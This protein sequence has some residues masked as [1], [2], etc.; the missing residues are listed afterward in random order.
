[1]AD[2][3]QL[4]CFVVGWLVDFEA[5]VVLGSSRSRCSSCSTFVVVVVVLSLLSL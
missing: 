4:A 3:L 2:K 1:M 5:F